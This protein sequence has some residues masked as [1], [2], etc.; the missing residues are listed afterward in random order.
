MPPAPIA[1]RISYGPSRVP[2]CKTTPVGRLYGSSEPMGTAS[3]V[4]LHRDVTDQPWEILEPLVHPCPSPKV[5]WP[6]ADVRLL[7]AAAL[8]C[9]GSGSARTRSARRTTNRKSG[10]PCQLHA[11]APRATFQGADKRRDS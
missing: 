10:G 5:C 4:E 6:L 1:D 11:H 2:G 9:S 7:S 3:V 8:A